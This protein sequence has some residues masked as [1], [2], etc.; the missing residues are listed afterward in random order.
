[1]CIRDRVHDPREQPEED[2][3]A[4]ALAEIL[5]DVEG[6]EQGHHPDADDEDPAEDGDPAQQYADQ[7]DPEPP[8]RTPGDLDP[9]VEVV[10]RDDGRPTGLTSLD[11]VSYTHLTLPTI[12]RV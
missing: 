12:L 3:E 9:D 2:A 10:E 1:M 4:R 11:A 7:H 8:G 5:G 6:E